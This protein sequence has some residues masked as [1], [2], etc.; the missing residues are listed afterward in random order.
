[1]KAVI[2]GAGLA[3]LTSAVVLKRAGWEVEIYE[4]RSQLGGMCADTEMLGMYVQ[5]FGPHVFHTKDAEVWKFMKYF[6]EFEPF[7]HT[8]VAQTAYTDELLP[9][10]YSL[11]TEEMIGRRLSDEEIIEWFLSGYSTKMWGSDWNDLPPYVKGRIG[12]LRRDNHDIHYFN[13]KYQGLPRFGFSHMFAQMLEAAGGHIHLGA[14]P[15]DWMNVMNPQVV[16]Y[17]GR[18]DAAFD[19]E[20]G[21]LAYRSLQFDLSIGGG[22]EEPVV[23]CCDPAI[24]EIRRSDF[25]LFNPWNERENKT[26]IMKEYPKDPETIDEGYYP[27]PWKNAP[28][29]LDRYKQL[30][31]REGAKFQVI[32]RLGGYAHK[33]MDAVIR[34]GI[35]A[36]RRV[37]LEVGV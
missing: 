32:G 29:T 14:G 4:T 33:N 31:T 26:V 36:A 11:E 22:L 34:E 13:D 10:P 1:M 24:E 19:F 5:L 16:I 7:I 23:N 18:L 8:V 3:G 17:T 9:I 28:K 20:H 27:M 37:I 12:K 30:A 2:V 15:R 6:T 35:D 21:E 25:G